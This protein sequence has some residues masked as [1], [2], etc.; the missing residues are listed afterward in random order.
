MNNHI[1]PYIGDKQLRAVTSV[2]LQSVMNHLEGRGKTLVGDVYSILTNSFMRAYA[3]GMVDRDPS[4]GLERPNTTRRNLRALTPEE[5]SAVLYVGSVHP[6]GLLLLLLY[7]TG[8][9]RGE[10][11]GLQWGDIDFEQKTLSVLRDVDHV[12]GAIGTVKTPASIRTIPIPQKL[13]D[14][15]R[16]LRGLPGVHVIQAPSSGSFLCEATYRRT[17]QS[18]MVA[19]FEYDGSIESEVVRTSK[20]KTSNVKKSGQMWMC[21]APFLLRTIFVT[22][23]LASFTMRMWMF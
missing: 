7:Y 23:M 18:L 14:V 9:R 5:T 1:L 12:T 11:L 22:T 17:W 6:H 20:L 21:S 4:V 8:M 10:A 19:M 2:D 3:A 13:Y 16:P 15:L